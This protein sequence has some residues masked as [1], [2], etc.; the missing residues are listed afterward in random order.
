MFLGDLAHSR[1]LHQG[2]SLLLNVLIGLL[3]ESYK[4]TLSWAAPKGVWEAVK[5]RGVCSSA[6]LH[7]NP[8]SRAASSAGAPKPEGRGAAGASPEG[9]QED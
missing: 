1:F 7:E 9:Y 3:M 2:F 4:P 8:I 6:P 5:G